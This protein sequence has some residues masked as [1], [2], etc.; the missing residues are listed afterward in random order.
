MSSYIRHLT[1]RAGNKTQFVPKSVDQINISLIERKTGAGFLRDLE[2]GHQKIL[3]SAN[4]G[5]VQQDTLPQL[6]E[7][8]AVCL[9][10][11]ANM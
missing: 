8:V 4:P 1:Q 9:P 10:V 11:A 7:R 6:K 3:E 2:K 5:L